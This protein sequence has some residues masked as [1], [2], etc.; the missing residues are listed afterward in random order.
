MFK[1]W[2]KKNKI[3]AVF[4]LQFHV[5]QV[6]KLKKSGVMISLV[7]ED[8]GKPTVRLEKVAVQDGTCTWENPVFE[9]MKLTR[10]SKTEKIKEKLYHFI[11]STGSSKSGYLG[12]ASID[13]ADFVAETEPLTVSLPLKFANSGAILNVTIQRMLDPDD[14]RDIE[15]NGAPR[16]QKNGSM[17]SQ[18]SSWDTDGNN[19]SLTENGNPSIFRDEEYETYDRKTT[20]DQ[21]AAHFLSHFRQKSM[22]R[23]GTVNGNKSNVDWLG[24]S[25]SDD[26]LIESP[27]SFEDQHVR[28]RPR[29]ASDDSTEK[30]K[31]EIA[32][33]MRQADL[34]EL[35]IQSL[36]KQVE[37]ES[38]QGQNLSRQIVS[39]KEERD[40]FKFECEQLKSQ[41]K[42]SEAEAPKRLQSE[43]R[44]TRAHLEAIRQELNH[45]KKSSTDLQ[46]QL[47]K[48]QDSNAELIQLVKDL[49]D[50]LEQKDTEIFELSSKMETAKLAKDGNDSKVDVLELKIKDLYDEIDIY[51]EERDKQIMRIK[52][53]TSNYDLLKQENYDMSLKLKRSQEEQ[54]EIENECQGYVET[55]KELES[56]AERLEE[57]IQKQAREFSEYLISINELEG[58]VKALEKELEKQAKGFEDKLDSVMREK[59]DQEQRAIQAEEALKNTRMNNSIRTESLQEEFRSLSLEMAS[60]VDENE[61]QAAKVQTEAN[62][63]LQQNRIL[64]EKLRKANKELGLIKDQEKVQLQELVHK[65]NMKEKQIEQMSM[66]L[67]DKSQQI[68]CAKRHEEEN[69]EAL[70]IEIQML[71]EEIERL[72]K[73]KSNFTE[74]GDGKVRSRDEAKQ[75]KRTICEKEM[76]IKRL[77]KEK[78]TLEAKFALAKQ[79]AEK[80]LKA[81]SLHSTEQ[82][83]VA[84]LMEKNKSMEKELKDMEGRYSEISLRFAEVEGERQQLVM[85]VR[86][87]RNNKKN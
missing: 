73:E 40:A 18:E 85:T 63:L 74:E 23:K 7:P 75:M 17:E 21:D 55:I 22:T 8:I 77:K 42:I 66:E 80:E 54:R 67:T 26:S 65:I 46:L 19:L 71:R 87:L 4:Q 34:S 39:V 13:F 35:E 2:S 51:K 20:A 82:T 12:E 56:Q 28:N 64:E 61:K 68:E 30:L 15:E 43:I 79:E 25:A 16:L 50:M 27:S 44:D 37:K 10:D 83:E 33:L 57:T 41:Q 45:E 72:K 48:T 78:D 70:S 32:I 31:N 58:Q 62:E 9:S 6:P 29:E 47:Q 5:T 14:Q 81:T 86:N 84:S 36:R 69:H 3:K 52:Q 49:E 76:L 11:V 38:K 53:L 59:V 60:K 1:S 24:D